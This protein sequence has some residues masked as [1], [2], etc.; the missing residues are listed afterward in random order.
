[1]EMSVSRGT[2]ARADSRFEH[3]KTSTVP[4]PSAL[5]AESAVETAI[6][7]KDGTGEPALTQAGVT[8]RVA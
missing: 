6:P 3:L 8:I 5:A 1:M 4:M 7:D 2:Q